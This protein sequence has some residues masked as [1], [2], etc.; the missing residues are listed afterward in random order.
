M[1]STRKIKLVLLL[2]VSFGC[3]SWLLTGTLFKADANS[4]AMRAVR[5]LAG[6]DA[7]LGVA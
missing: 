1:A 6:T 5:G 4:A 3:V 7:S 2:A